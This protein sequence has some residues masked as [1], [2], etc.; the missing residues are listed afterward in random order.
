MI[1]DLALGSHE[2]VALVGGGGKTTLLHA[3]GDRLTGTVVLTSTTKMAADEHAGRPV[4]LAPAAAEVVDAAERETVMVW[5]SV[6]GDKA[7]GVAPQ[8]C[9]EWFELVDHVIVEADGSR[10]R[11][12]KAPATHEPVIPDTIT[13]M[14]SVIGA[15]ALGRVIG[16][17]CHRPLRVAALAGCRPYERLTPAGA[18]RVLLHERGARKSMPAGAR[19]VVAI[20]KTQDA[21]RSLVDE[22][23]RELHEHSPETTVVLVEPPASQHL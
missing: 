14:I 1:A 6:V 20:T 16:D 9:D 10:G 11:P 13:V 7:V 21:N 22:L 8:R 17:Q 3:L 18:A 5:Q 4:L 15:D 19:M 12:F 2:H 23:V